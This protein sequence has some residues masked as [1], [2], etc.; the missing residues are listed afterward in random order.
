MSPQKLGQIGRRDVQADGMGD[1][2]SAMTPLH[3][4]HVAVLAIRFGLVA[5]AAAVLALAAMKMAAFAALPGPAWLL[6]AF[7]LLGGVAATAILPVRRYRGWGYRESEDE[8]EI[9]RGRLVRVRTIVPFGRVQH[10]DVA[11]GPIQRMFGLGTLILHTAGTQGASV[12]LP[13][14]P[15]AQAETMRD[16]IR[17]KIRQDLV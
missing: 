12:P 1:E 2:A 11:Q 9:R 17:A 3:P 5:A 13:G 10:I 14:L 4:A 16:R 15:V 6:P 8:I 7:V